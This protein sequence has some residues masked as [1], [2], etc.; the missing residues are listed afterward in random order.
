MRHLLPLGWSVVVVAALTGTAAEDNAERKPDVRYVP[1][2]PEVV[3][4]MLEVAR[5]TKKDVVYDL[6]CGDG[7]IVIAAAKKYG[8]KAIGFDID[9]ERIKDSEKNKAKLPRDVRKLVTFK[10]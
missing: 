6:G 5:V 10:K 3:D 4:K 1:T 8:C 9:P 2:P 7:R